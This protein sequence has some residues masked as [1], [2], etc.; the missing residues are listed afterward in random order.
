MA[1]WKRIE[2]LLP[3]V[4]PSPKGGRPRVSDQR[5]LNGILCTHSRQ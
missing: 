1:L 5:A 4:K 3:E 2:L